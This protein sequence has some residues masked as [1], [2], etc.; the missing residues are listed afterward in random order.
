MKTNTI[1]C[2]G[3]IISACNAEVDKCSDSIC[4]PDAAT[5]YKNDALVTKF[6]HEKGVDRERANQLFEETKSFLVRAASV[7][8]PIEPPSREVDAMWHTFILFT[9]DYLVFCRNYLGTFVHHVPHVL[10]GCTS[11]QDGSQDGGGMDCHS[12]ASARQFAG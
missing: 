10:G 7:R 1:H 4:T 12:I 2:D 3:I 8:A 6:S 9:K 5:F 11:D